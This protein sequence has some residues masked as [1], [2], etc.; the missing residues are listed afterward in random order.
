VLGVTARQVVRAA[1]AGREAQERYYDRVRARGR[2]VLASVRPEDRAVVVVGRLY[3]THDPGSNLDLPLKLRRLGVL[4]VPMDYLPV[5]QRDVSGRYGNMFWRSGQDIL[6]AAEI[7]R[8][9]P[10]LGAVYLTNFSCGP[11][12][13]L[14]GFFRRIMGQK[15]FLQLEV[16][17]HTADAGILTRCEAFL[18]SAG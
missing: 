7:I 17:D 9:D 6:A 4:P 18:E 10:R 12:S 5:E 13:F 14:V 8:D 2:E 15:P 11:D 1:G 16:D 3:N